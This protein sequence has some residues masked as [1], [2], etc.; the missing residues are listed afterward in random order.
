VA[1]IAAARP[2]STVIVCAG[3]T[4]RSASDPF[5]IMMVRRNDTVAFMAG[6]YVFPGGRVDEGDA[7][8]AG[9]ACDPATFPASATR[10]RPPI[11][12]LPCASCRRKRAWP[13][14]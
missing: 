13:D 9:A 14:G 1:D 8:R 10:K 2:A 12:R 3:P 11:A 6:S 5:E 7:P 4:A